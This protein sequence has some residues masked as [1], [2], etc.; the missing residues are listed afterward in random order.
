MAECDT[1]NDPSEQ[2]DFSEDGK[3]RTKIFCERCSSLVLLPKS[4]MY[5][6]SE[7]FMPHMKKKK[8]G[9]DSNGE[10]LSDF[11]KVG[12]MFTFENVGFCNTVDNIKYL[13]CADCEVGPIG[14]HDISDKTAYYIALD[15][16]VHK[17]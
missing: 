5:C 4:A 17:D 15:R 9:L 10:K 14:W 16:V 1:K 12:D 13:V 2:N 6:K 3:N 8:E 7:F 11:W